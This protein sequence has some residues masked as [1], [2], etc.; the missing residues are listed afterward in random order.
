[1]KKRQQIQ[2]LE[3]IY[4]HS[5]VPNP[6]TIKT[7]SNICGYSEETVWRWRDK[8]IKEGLLQKPENAKSFDPYLHNIDAFQELPVIKTFSDKCTTNKKNPNTYV[9]PLFKICRTLTVHPEK[10]VENIEL[11]EKLY[12]EFERKWAEIKPGSSTERHRKAIRKFIEYSTIVLPKRSIAIPGTSERGGDYSKVHLTDSEVNVGEHFIEENSTKMYSSLFLMFHEFFPRPDALFNW[13]PD[14]ELLH[15]D[16]DGRTYEYGQTTIFEPKQKRS[17]DKLIFDPR[18]LAIIKELPNDRTIIEGM[19]EKQGQVER[20]LS[21]V[22]RQFYESIGRIDM[23]LK[24]KKGQHGWLYTHKPIY[25]ER[26]SSATMWLRRLNYNV[27]FVA[28]MGWED[29][30]T[31]LKYYAKI[32][33][34][35]IMQQNICYYCSPP[36]VLT[37]RASF[38]CAAHAV[39]YINGGRK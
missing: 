11:S 7:L 17:F 26:H 33:I 18:V 30:K 8:L 29:P 1:M 9:Y 13:T 10:L 27:P 34:N 5:N 19:G 20:K 3:Q 37:D 2:L 39:A 25:T 21:V 38:C 24:Y 16:V 12:V 15:I 32:T 31:L 22:L 35:N 14:I 36:N 28:S 6:P 4:K 23:S